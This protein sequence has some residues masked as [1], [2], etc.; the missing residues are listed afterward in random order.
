MIDANAG[1]KIKGFNDVTKKQ[2][3]VLLRR[4][5]KIRSPARAGVTR[6]DTGRDPDT[7]RVGSWLEEN[8]LMM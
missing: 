5:K 8:I 4:R 6:R 7:R 3:C 2:Q 1:T